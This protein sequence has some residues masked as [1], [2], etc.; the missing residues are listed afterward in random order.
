MMGVGISYA[1]ACAKEL[2]DEGRP[3]GRMEFASP[4][5]PAME[6]KLRAPAYTA[7]SG[8]SV[9]LLMTSIEKLALTSSRSTAAIRRR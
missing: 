1:V 5:A 4:A 7:F 6:K 3:A 2:R 8:N 9:V